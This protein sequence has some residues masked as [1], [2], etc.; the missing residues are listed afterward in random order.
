M[1]QKIALTGI[2]LILL[3]SSSY[4]ASLR[5]SVEKAINTNPDIIAEK[6][7]QEAYRKYVDDREGLYLPTLD[8]E[9]Y[10]ETSKIEKDYDDATPDT[11]S[12]EDG[13]NA[14][15]VFRQYLYDGGS[16]P[17]QV[18]EVKHQELAN[19]YRSF[20]AIENTILE[21]VKAYTGLVQSDEKLALTNDMIK[22]HEENLVT[23]K[24]KE[25]ISGEVLETYQ[26]S[27]KLN[28]TI[29]KYIEEQSVKETG[30]AQYVKYVGE[31]LNGSI[32]RPTIDEAKV[33]A[34]LKEAI[35]I[36]VIRNH[37]ILEQ[38]EKI[39]LQREKIAQY[40]ARFLPSLNL[41][42]KASIDDDLE[43]N[44]NGTQKDRYAR[45]NLNWNLFNGNRDSIRSE[46][47][48]IFLQEQKKTLDEITNDVVAEIKSLYTKFYKNK[49]RVEALK[50][51]VVA[52]VNIVEVYRNEFQAGTRTFV[53][54]LDA[55]SELYNSRTSLINIEYTALNNYYDLMFNLSQL[56][57]TVLSS[58]NQICDNVSPR[59]FSYTPK[60]QDKQ[61]RFDLDGLISNTDSSIISKELGLDKEIAETASS[62]AMKM[63]TS[64]YKTFL[65][66][67]KNYY[68]INIATK[69]GMA[70]ASK[71]IRDNNLGDNAY[72]F[73]FGP[74]MRSAK[75]LY[76]VYSSVE[77]A[78]VAMRSLSSVVLANKPYIDNIR[79]HQA[80]YAKYN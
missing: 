34:T 58:E 25:E 62:D 52:N 64:E 75:I 23:A 18:S 5:D 15:I 21:T 59:V 40:D 46:Q 10:L 28:F 68:T 53:D 22:N 30:M 37:R 72:S 73:E 38:I 24:E 48:T 47:E 32:C 31:E 9:A 43:L 36:A 27:S 33:P 61:S 4:A 67:P 41:E 39:K 70:A 29:D 50:K 8:I 13:Y 16:T 1:K 2:C 44:E 11:K 76:G 7:N 19:K 20:Y 14:A 56:T 45:L 17:S 42:L 26:V 74:S 60:E 66:A 78:K 12:D 54:I 57:D 51:Y 3:T 77:E 69:N 6:K 65:D 35:E 63:A 80:L 79:K 49:K 55:E 71:Y